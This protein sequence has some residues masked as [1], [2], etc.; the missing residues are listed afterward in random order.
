MANNDDKVNDNDSVMTLGRLSKERIESL[1][2]VPVVYDKKAGF[3]LTKEVVNQWRDDLYDVMAAGNSSLGPSALIELNDQLNEATAELDRYKDLYTASQTQIGLLNQ[4]LAKAKDGLAASERISAARQTEL[5]AEVDRITFEFNRVTSEHKEIKKKHGAKAT[6]T[7]ESAKRVTDLNN[8]LQEAHKLL[9][10]EKLSC[11]ALAAKVQKLESDIANMEKLKQRQAERTWADV[12]NDPPPP[13]DPVQPTG[14]RLID[15]VVNEK[16]RE[17]LLKEASTKRDDARE[18][19]W[20]L[21]QAAREVDPKNWVGWRQYTDI[22]FKKVK[23]ASYKK[24]QQYLPLID[25]V[26][27]ALR[28]KTGPSIDSVKEEFS[29]FFSTD[30]VHQAKEMKTPVGQ[31]TWWQALKFDFWLARRRLSLTFWETKA[32]FDETGWMPLRWVSGPWNWLKGLF[33]RSRPQ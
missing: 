5:R 27:E 22:L 8:Q 15:R 18:R 29:S 12:A 7:A 21:L 6:E 28:S 4:D 10:A 9:N 31:E 11:T 23:T 16:A 3:F 13:L 1:T 33:T 19:A 30:P 24:R 32:R 17:E 26:S 25:K 2:G 20:H 14:I